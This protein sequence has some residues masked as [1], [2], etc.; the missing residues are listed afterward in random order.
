MKTN[1]SEV[2]RTVSHWAARLGAA[3][4]LW[5]QAAEAFL[6]VRDRRALMVEGEDWRVERMPA[7]AITVTFFEGT[8][9]RQL[10]L[11]AATQAGE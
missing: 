10:A 4:N 7:D 8:G 6:F 1:E 2:E 11:Q 3:E 5:H 9:R